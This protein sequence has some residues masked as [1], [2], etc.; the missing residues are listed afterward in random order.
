MN[1]ALFDRLSAVQA[2]LLVAFVPS[3]GDFSESTAWVDENAN[4]QVSQLRETGV[5]KGAVAQTLL[6]PAV[7]QDFAQAVLLV[8]VGKEAQLSDMQARKVVAAVA[9]QIKGL[10]FASVAVASEGLVLKNRS[11]SD[12]LA[13]VAQWL[14]EGFY[15]FI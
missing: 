14:N 13:L 2:D 6:L 5:F 12:V 15:N 9:A 4:G 10:P 8:G 7:S 3:E 11:A 1:M